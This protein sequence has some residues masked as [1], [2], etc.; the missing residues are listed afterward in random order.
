VTLKK[1]LEGPEFIMEENEFLSRIAY[2]YYKQDMDLKAIG[3]AFNTSYATISRSLKRARELGIITININNPIS[4][5][6]EQEIALKERFKLRD[7]IAV[8][9]SE[10]SSNDEIKYSVA[11]E[12]ASYLINVIKDGDKLGIS[13]GS[14]IYQLINN[15]IAMGGLFNGKKFDIDVVQLNGNFS[16]IPI[17]LNSLDLVR[18]MKNMFAGSYYFL[19]SEAYVDSHEMQEFLLKSASIQRTFTMHKSVNIAL[20]GIGAFNVQ[21]ISK[22][23]KDYLKLEEIIEIGNRKAIGENCLTFYDI[24]GNVIDTDLYKRTITISKEDLINIQNKVVIA[25]GKEKVNAI[26][27]AVR[28]KTVDI[29][30]TDSQT[31]EEVLNNPN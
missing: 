26:I 12:A 5:L 17:E 30:I 21:S 6:L 20:L 23:Y 28:A 31:L 16:T 7:V 29:L 2:M 27:G 13:W 4:R 19:N 18:R 15:F 8:N 24:D 3:K 22:L 10:I 11:R 1:L 9:V 25:T 14:T